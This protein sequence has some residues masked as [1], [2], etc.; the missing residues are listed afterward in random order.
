MI[1]S[2]YELR[3]L[4]RELDDELVEVLDVFPHGLKAVA[5][6]LSVRLLHAKKATHLFAPLFDLAGVGPDLG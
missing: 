5:D 2:L 4:L 3:I 6:A 1:A